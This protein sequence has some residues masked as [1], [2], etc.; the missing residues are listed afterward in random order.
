MTPPVRSWGLPLALLSV[1]LFLAP[2]PPRCTPVPVEPSA[3]C[4]ADAD[5]ADGEPCTVAYCDATTGVCVYDAVADGTPCDD[6]NVCTWHDVCVAGQCT[7]G[8]CDCDDGNPC[9]DD[10]VDPAVGCVHVPLQEAPCDDGDVCT[11]GDSCRQGVCVGA[12]PRN[13]DDGNPCTADACHPNV[14]CA[15]RLTENC[16]GLHDE[17]CNDMFDNDQDGLVDM[18]D[19]DCAAVPCCPI[20]EDC[21]NGMDDDGD[22][23]VDCPDPDCRDDQHCF[24]PGDVDCDGVAN[25]GDNCP[26]VPNPDQA[27][28]DHDGVGDACDPDD[29]A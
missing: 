1:V 20:P 12:T 25:A 2:A 15:H 23:L 28:A 9:T 11:V 18:D 13:C 26:H 7:G 21:S 6:Q 4:V 19:P 16:A 29:D 5:C 24:C 8:P 17:R 10:I 22:G 27:D 14:G 3:E